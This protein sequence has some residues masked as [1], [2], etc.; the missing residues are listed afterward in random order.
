MKSKGTL[1][2]KVIC[3]PLLVYGVFS[4]LSYTLTLALFPVIE[5]DE[6]TLYALSQSGINMDETFAMLI[7]AAIGALSMTAIGL[8]GLLGSKLERRLY[9]AIAADIIAGIWCLSVTIPAFA[10]LAI[11]SSID[12]AISIIAPIAITVG[13]ILNY[14]SF[15]MTKE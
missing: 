2:I 3:I 12:I 5:S 13:I 14:R 7:R 9:L 4:L 15:K 1:L 10:N 8:L 6:A 11:T